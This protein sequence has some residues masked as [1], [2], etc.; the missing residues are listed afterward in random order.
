MEKNI[1]QRLLK[2]KTVKKK[3]N[4]LTRNLIGGLII[5]GVLAASAL[6][7]LNKQTKEITGEWLPSLQLAEKINTRTSDYRIAQYRHLMSSDEQTRKEAESELSGLSQEITSM[8]E[9]YESYILAEEDVKLMNQAE[10][11]WAAYEEEGKEIIR[12]SSAGKVE[13]ANVAML[14]E[15]REYYTQFTDTFDQIVIYNEEGIA[16]AAQKAQNVYIV[17]IILITVIVILVAALGLRIAGA[18]TS[19]IVDP[20][21]EVSRVLSSIHKGDLDVTI[22]YEAKDEFGELATIVSEFLEKLASIINDEKYLL[23][24]MATGNFDITSRET[25]QYVGGFAPILGSMRK[26]NRGLGNTLSSIQDAGYQISSASEQMAKEA[27]ELADG[28]AEQ[29]GTVEELAAGVGEVTGQSVES[30]KGAAKVS[31][32]VGEVK[33]EA[34]NGNRQMERVVEAMEVITQTSN[35]IA[36]IIDAIDSIASQTNLLSLNASIEAARAGEAGKGFAVVASEIGQLAKEC[37]EAANNTRNLIGKSV[38]QT[39]DG[40]DI[41]KETAEGLIVVQEKAAEAVTI[42]EAVKKNSEK[43][44]IAMQEI[45]RGIEAISRVVETNSASAQESSATSEE[46]AANADTLRDELEKFKFKRQD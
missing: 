37:S 45:E 46:L 25:E 10:S 23:G 9:V 27:Q 24:E 5:V 15:S 16:A 7:I 18:V 22:V 8:R 20:L 35:E 26:I 30:A 13:E 1:F 40:N 36:T 29:A 14:G 17:V 44:E 4:F 42:A 43:Q 6:M 11:L 32:M 12:L 33:K 34:E 3:M 41:V 28:A 31:D 19:V 38:L 2:N 21:K 39:Q